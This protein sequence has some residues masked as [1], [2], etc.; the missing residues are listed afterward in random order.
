MTD[1]IPT[2]TLGEIEVGVT[3]WVGMPHVGDKRIGVSEWQELDDGRIRALLMMDGKPLS[4][5]GERSFDGQDG[6]KL[7]GTRKRAVRYAKQQEE[8]ELNKEAE[9]E[10]K[11]AKVAVTPPPGVG[12]S[13]LSKGV[14]K[15]VHDQHGNRKRILVHSGNVDTHRKHRD[16]EKPE[17]GHV[18]SR[19]LRINQRVKG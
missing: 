4:I 6:W 14:Y 13:L 10:V 12:K 5:I 1:N 8:M 16:P 19:Y 3:I 9:K 15:T 2:I 7:F 11:S 17:Q 18:P